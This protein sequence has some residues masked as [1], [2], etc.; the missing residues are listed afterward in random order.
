M[1]RHPLPFDVRNDSWLVEAVKITVGD[2]TPAITEVETKEEDGQIQ[3]CGALEAII[4]TE[5]YLLFRLYLPPT[6]IMQ[7]ILLQR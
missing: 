6:T 5:L 2:E 7:K 1:S 4:P 3:V